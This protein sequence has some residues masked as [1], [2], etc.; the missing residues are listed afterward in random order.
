VKA[1]IVLRSDRT[2]G[3][4]LEEEIRAFVK[5][6]LSPHEYPRVIE[7]V[8]SLPMT[9]TGKIRR[10]ELRKREISRIRESG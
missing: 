4:A 10:G 8:D 7:F 6:R 3:A 9:A 2:A 5:S 1:F